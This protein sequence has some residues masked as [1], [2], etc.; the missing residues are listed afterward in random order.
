MPGV[1]DFALQLRSI[2]DVIIRFLKARRREEATIA[3]AALLLWIGYKVSDWLPKELAE[4]LKPWHGVLIGQSVLYL[5]GLA[6]LIHAFLRIKRL[7]WVED[8]PP[9]KDR[10]SAIKGPMAFTE[11]DDELPKLFAYVTVHSSINLL[12]RIL[13]I[14]ITGSS[15]T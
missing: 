12:A 15:H 2:I 11:A 4:F 3:F 8:L 6:L 13:A 1:Q 10:P 14:C 5:V 9:A 7:V